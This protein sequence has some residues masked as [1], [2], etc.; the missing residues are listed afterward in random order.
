ML[1]INK[2]ISLVGMPGAGKTCIG[3]EIAK[4][5]DLPFIDAD[6]EIKK[7]AGREIVDIFKEFGEE[8]FREG[9][10]KVIKRILNSKQ[11]ILATGGGSFINTN[12][13]KI[14]KQKSM[15]VFINVEL[16]IL[17]QRIQGKKHRPLLQGNSAKKE[18]ENTL[19]KRY[20]IYKQADLHIKYSNTNSPITMAK[21]IIK[22][23][24]KYE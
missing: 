9:E 7:S 18:L 12:T 10:T 17:W 11:C 14:I 5:T 4:L 24:K 13:N 8:H 3:R 6:V 21:L 16:D 20:D 23:L 2:S 19:K 22:K 15:S 1:K